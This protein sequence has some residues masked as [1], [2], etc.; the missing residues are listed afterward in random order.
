MLPGMAGIMAGSGRAAFQPVTYR[1]AGAATSGTGG[2]TVDY[3]AGIV[4]GEVALLRVATANQPIATP[5]GFEVAKANFGA[6]GAAGG[7]T[8]Q[9]LQYF[10]QIYVSGANISLP[11][12]G[13]HILAQI[14]AYG[15]ADY[16]NFIDATAYELDFRT[17]NGGA[18]WTQQS[19]AN[20]GDGFPVPVLGAM[21]CV[22]Q[23]TYFVS[24]S[25]ISDPLFLDLSD[26]SPQIS[27]DAGPGV[28]TTSSGN[29]SAIYLRHKPVLGADGF[30]VGPLYNAS[31]TTLSG[32]P[33]EAFFIMPTG[34]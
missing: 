17:D 9:C 2:V 16:T 25:I 26:S 1:G 29:D 22:S 34:S 20:G 3:P 31:H 15:N 30:S 21:I 23:A 8:S 10:K 33:A 13:D 24:L 5:S 28:I 18:S 6:T 19:G 14:T 4:A 11:D 7:S 27:L 12:A 32:E